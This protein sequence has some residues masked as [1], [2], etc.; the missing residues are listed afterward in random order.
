MKKLE[1]IANLCVLIAGAGLW[2]YV[3]RHWT[4]D[5]QE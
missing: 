1:A 5:D 3:I 2:I 4:R